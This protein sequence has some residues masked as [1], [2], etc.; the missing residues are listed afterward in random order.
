MR[1]INAAGLDIIKRE[2]LLKT[3]AYL[4]PAGIPTIGYGHTAGVHLGQVIT[5]A[6]ADEF[7]RADLAVAEAGVDGLVP[8]ATDNEFS[9]L[10]SFAFNLGVPALAASGLV[11]KYRSG[12]KPAAA[13]DFLLWTHAR[14][15]ATSL[16]RELPG[17]VR[18]RAEERDLFLTP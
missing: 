10:V 3:H 8:Q 12:N 11:R 4:C 2:E 16:M 9:A 7:L 1:T 15:P 5:E 17:L 6:Q 18:R 13:A 14:D